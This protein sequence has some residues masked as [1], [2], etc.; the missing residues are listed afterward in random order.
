[1]AWTLAG[2]TLPSPALYK[3][4]RMF[5]GSRV[6][7]ANAQV[8]TDLLSTTAKHNFYLEWKMLSVTDA[9]YV[10]TA[11]D[12]AAVANTAGVTF[13]DDLGGSYSVVIDPASVELTLEWVPFRSGSPRANVS[14]SLREV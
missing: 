7:K 2:Q 4:P 14:I 12:L 9:G 1:M 8:G 13:V 3:R 11:F 5:R 6:I 10:Q